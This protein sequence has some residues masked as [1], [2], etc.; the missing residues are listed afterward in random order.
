MGANTRSF[1]PALFDF[2]LDLKRNNNRDWFQSNK[3]RYEDEVR[4]PGLQFISDFGPNLRKIS[5]SFE[6]DPRPVG[7]S[8]F[9]IY[10]DVRFSKDKSPYKTAVGIQFRHKSRRDVHSPGF[11][12]H[13]EPDA[14]FAGVG[15]YHPD[16]ATLGQIRKF[17]VD[18][19]SRWK[20]VT[21]GARFR[22]AFELGGASLKRAPKGYDPEHPLIEDLKRKDFVAFAQIPDS[23][24]TKPGFLDEYTRLCRS[25]APL[26]RLLCEAVDVPY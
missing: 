23:E 20:R 4:H 18:S 11:Y 6:A 22:E 2:L 17:L 12:L 7:G 13:L 9:R 21:N 8:M 1:S 16:G 10:R 19:S 14:C 15:I 25:G 5:P 24:V 26:V 3:E